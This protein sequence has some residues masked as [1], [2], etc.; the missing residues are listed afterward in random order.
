MKIAQFGIL[1]FV[2]VC[3]VASC[4]RYHQDQKLPSD[5]PTAIT[6]HIEHAILSSSKS[7]TPST[8]HSTRSGQALIERL[9]TLEGELYVD[10]NEPS[11]WMM[12][13]TSPTSAVTI[14]ADTAILR[15]LCK[16][17]GERIQA[18]GMMKKSVIGRAIVVAEYKI[19]RGN[20]G[21]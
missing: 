5:S 10:G 8:K 2:L 6:P 14:E 21:K 15:N 4:S 7:D 13:S 3:T 17:Q 1:S 9:D 16:L 18:V 20:K 11:S 12:L 19:V